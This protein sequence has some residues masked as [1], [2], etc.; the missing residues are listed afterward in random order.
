M[1][2]PREQ[3]HRPTIPDVRA[4]AIVAALSMVLA[5]AAC[6]DGS[7]SNAIPNAPAAETAATIAATNTPTSPPRSSA[8]GASTP[9]TV[10][11]T[12]PSR[13]VKPVSVTFVSPQTGWVLDQP[14]CCELRLWQTRDAGTTW[15]KV[16]A[17]PIQV[18]SRTTRE[19]GVRFAN[20]RDGY[21]FGPS[22]WATHDGGASWN[23]VAF[24]HTS[25]FGYIENLEI[26]NRRAYALV[27][28][29]E[30]DH[31]YRLVSSAVDGNTWTPIY[32]SGQSAAP[33][34]DGQLLATG[35]RA[36]LLLNFRVV[37]GG[38][39]ITDGLA[40]DW[41]PPCTGT[42]GPGS[43]AASNATEL[44]ALCSENQWS[45]DRSPRW[46]LHASH[47]AGTTFSPI[48]FATAATNGGPCLATA[49]V[50][51]VIVGGSGFTATFDRGRTWQTVWPGDDSD[52]S[53]AEIGFTTTQQGVAIM[54][55]EHPALLMTRDGGRSWNQI[56]L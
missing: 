4:R 39:R 55:G 10:E 45:G 37:T 44:V 52:R 7:G 29:G 19:F 12:V 32:S 46:T 41:T 22:L 30:V 8:P 25:G 33:V 17:P 43:I 20:V 14:D 56:T 50:D 42:F 24:P 3:P 40:R 31:R 21:V 47:D 6:R 27:S 23:E 53:C 26:S 15:K 11:L 48:G 35:D 49:N 5:L 34:G 51:T 38:A 28:T 2:R 16:T 18:N 1:A 54:R 13:E 9:F 36:Y